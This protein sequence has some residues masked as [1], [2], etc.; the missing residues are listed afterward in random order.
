[1][2]LPAGVCGSAGFGGTFHPV[3]N[4]AGGIH[5]NEKTVDRSTVDATNRHLKKLN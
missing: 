4:R 2:N 1:M 3:H 5:F